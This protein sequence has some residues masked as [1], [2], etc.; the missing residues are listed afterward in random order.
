MRPMPQAQQMYQQMPMPQ[1]MYVNPK[2]QEYQAHIHQMFNSQEFM[3][4]SIEARK[5]II[6]TAIFKFVEEMVGQQHAP[7][8]TGMIIDLDP[9]DLNQSVAKYDALCSKVN[10][11]MSLLIE[12]G[13]VKAPQQ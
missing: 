13:I 1:P 7:K 6:G 12:K 5:H 2:V 11:A 3:T 8:V 4:S 9:I 10:S